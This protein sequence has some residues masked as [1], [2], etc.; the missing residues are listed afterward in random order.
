MP[1]RSK[2]GA[3]ILIAIW[4]A[5]T[6]VASANGQCPNLSGNY[7]AV[8]EDGHVQ[9]TIHQQGCNRIDIIMKS[10]YLGTITSETHNLKLDGK[11]QKDSSWFGSADQYRTSAEFVGS[12]LQVR[13]STTGGSTVRMNYSL[14]RDRDLL[15]KDLS[16]PRDVPVVAKRQ[17]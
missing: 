11:E 14:T 6:H 8:G 4:L 15:E 2:C 12:E 10:N 9:I 13:A 1:N 17:K 5:A 3:F 16:N 7:V